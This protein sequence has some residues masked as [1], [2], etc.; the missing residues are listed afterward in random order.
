MKKTKNNLIFFVSIL[1]FLLVANMSL[2]Q[3]N[4]NNP[5][6]Q[7]HPRKGVSQSDA[8]VDTTGVPSHHKNRS[9]KNKMGNHNDNEDKNPN[10][11]TAV[12][13]AILLHPRKH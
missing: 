5:N 12:T 7:L 8:I 1:L 4:N 10:D 2:G 13:P 3:N 9:G 6:L 11:S